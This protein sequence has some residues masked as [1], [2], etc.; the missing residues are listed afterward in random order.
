MIIREYTD[1]EH[2]GMRLPWYLGFCW[3]NFNIRSS[4]YAVMPLNWLM[5]WGRAAYYR[6]MAGPRDALEEK[7][8][9]VVVEER[10]WGLINGYEDGH[11]AGIIAE[12]KRF[13]TVFDEWQAER[14]A[15]REEAERE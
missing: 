11:K 8:E 15:R 7:Y 1:K 13:Q 9:K 5:G 12:R 6:L 2:L 3:R 10:K 14:L 4:T